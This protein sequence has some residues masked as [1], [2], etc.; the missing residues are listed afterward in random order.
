MGLRLG[1]FCARNRYYLVSCMLQI[2]V[3]SLRLGKQVRTGGRAR[4]RILLMC[5]RIL[6][7]Y[8]T[9]PPE[10]MRLEDAKRPSRRP[11]RR[12]LRM[13]RLIKRRLSKR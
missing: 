8:V 13:V 3:Q 9:Q 10:Q 7:S 5:W 2:C 6:C 11:T 4:D 12:I 1:D